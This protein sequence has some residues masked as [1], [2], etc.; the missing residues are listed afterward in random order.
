MLSTTY[1]PVNIA[2]LYN[3]ADYRPLQGK[4][5]LRLHRHDQFTPGG[6]VIPES[7]RDLKIDNKSS[8]ATVLKMSPRTG[9]GKYA[10]GF[11]VG[12]TVLIMLRL[13]DLSRAEGIIITDNTRVYCVV[14]K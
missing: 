9:W 4:C 5:L 7:A 13:E 2:Y 14:D 12:D 6:L 10:E 3:L 1:E 11:N 8:L